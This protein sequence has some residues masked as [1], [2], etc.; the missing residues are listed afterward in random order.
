MVAEETKKLIVA[1]QGLEQSLLSME[2]SV[3]NLN[4]ISTWLVFHTILC[5]SM[6][7]TV[8]IDAFK[9]A[10]DGLRLSRVEGEVSI[11]NVEDAIESFEAEVCFE[12]STET[13][14]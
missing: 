4:I 11:N 1:Q 9:I 7:L 5:P 3:M 6:T 10:A 12:L 2:G 8:H 14:S 13:V